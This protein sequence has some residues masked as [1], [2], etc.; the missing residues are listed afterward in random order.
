MLNW[1]FRTM[2]IGCQLKTVRAGGSKTRAQPGRVLSDGLWSAPKTAEL[3]H[4]QLNPSPPAAGGEGWEQ[5]ECSPLESSSPRSSPCSCGAGNA[6]IR[7]R[8]IFWPNHRTVGEGVTTHRAPIRSRG[9]FFL[10]LC[11]LA[12]LM[13]PAVQAQP[14]DETPRIAFDEDAIYYS[15][16]IADGPV[17]RLQR[18]IDPA[19]LDAIGRD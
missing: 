10:V 13:V 2:N 3:P 4:D 1:F 12:A 7:V 9:R 6:G 17:A 18:R 5:E 15:S 8:R 11:V 14:Q 19:I 16:V